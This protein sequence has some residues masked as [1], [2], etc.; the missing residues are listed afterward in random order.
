MRSSAVARSTAKR[1]AV[2]LIA[3]TAWCSAG[4][5]LAAGSAHALVIDVSGH[6]FGVDPRANVG[7][8]AGGGARPAAAASPLI[9]AYATSVT[10]N[11]SATIDHATTTH[12][13]S[14]QTESVSTS[15]LTTTSTSTGGSGSD[16]STSTTATSTTQ[17]TTSDAPL[18][19]LQWHG[20]PVIRNHATYA[21]YWDPAGA[22]PPD[23]E[24]GVNQYFQDVAGASGSSSNVYSVLSQY[25]DASGP[26]VYQSTFGGPLV[27][28]NPYPADDGTTACPAS[29]AL[30]A[31]Y[32]WCVS[33]QQIRDELGALIKQQGWPATTSAEYFIFLPPGIDECFTGSDGSEFSQGCADNEFCSYHSYFGTGQPPLYAVLPWADV[34]GCQTGYSPNGAGGDDPVDDQLSLVAHEHSETITDP[35]GTSWYDANGNEVAD[36]C[37]DPDQFGALT[38]VDPNEY[39]Q[40]ISGDTYILQDNYSNDGATCRSSYMARFNTPTRPVIFRPVRFY[41]IAPGGAPGV[42]DYEWSFGDGAT[43]SGAFVTHTYSTPGQYT[44]TLS[45]TAA[46]GTPDAVSHTI[47]VSTVISQFNAPPQAEAGQPASFDGTPSLGSVTSYQW[48]FG[49]GATGIGIWTSHTYA[50]AGSY[51]VTLTVSDRAGDQDTSTQIVN[52]GA[53]APSTLAANTGSSSAPAPS[54]PAPGPPSVSD[55]TSPTPAP[56]PTD[57]GPASSA[58][59][60]AHTVR[61]LVATLVRATIARA[62]STIVRTTGNTT[63][64]DTGETVT[65]PGGA[66][67]CTV[68]VTLIHVASHPQTARHHSITLSARRVLVAP[69]RSTRL[70]LN[71]NPEGVRLLRGAGH[72]RTALEIIVGVSGGA[73]TTRVLP[74]TLTAPATHSR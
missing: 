13:T 52:V 1:I 19:P 46:D 32:T 54:A 8:P 29:T 2:R 28:T 69:G 15:F 4:C 43:A 47:A 10:A 22:F 48:A 3:L 6:R 62:A 34:P 42:T 57:G 25:S 74:L 70:A 37:T 7:T 12:A 53:L 21:I 49:D 24:S 39:N 41:A 38:G 68:A 44:V 5:A 33:D 65:C 30:P 67:W 66:G 45:T 23:F 58:P 59:P 26:G 36:D 9:A 20:G 16:T 18:L 56:A 63:I 60:A 55:P 40:L 11:S 31:G 72:L 14:T 35:F 61:P 51:V 17:T 64:A 27:D 73:S 50:S 71:L